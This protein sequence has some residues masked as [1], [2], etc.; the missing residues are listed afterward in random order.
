MGDLVR[1]SGGGGGGGGVVCELVSYYASCLRSPR[2]GVVG[3]HRVAFDMWGRPVSVAEKLAG[4]GEPDRVLVS[5]N[6]VSELKRRRVTSRKF[7]ASKVR[8]RVC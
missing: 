8:A 7:E 4:A 3:A 5:P 1:E 2:P 6:I